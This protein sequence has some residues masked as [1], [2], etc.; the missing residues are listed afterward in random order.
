[1]PA[2]D[3]HRDREPEPRA[4]GLPLG[5]EEGLEDPVHDLRGDAHTVVAHAD[6]HPVPILFDLFSGNPDATRLATGIAAHQRVARVEDQIEEDLLQLLTPRMQDRQLLGQVELD[7]DALLL[8]PPRHEAERPADDLR[9]VHGAH[10]FLAIAS[11]VQQVTHDRGDA[12]GLGDDVV[13]QFLVVVAVLNELRAVEDRVDRVV[14]LVRDAGGE[15]ADRGEAFGLHQHR[16]HLLAI[17][18]VAHD[19]DEFDALPLPHLADRNLTGEGLAI[20][21][22]AHDTPHFAIARGSPS[23]R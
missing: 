20:R 12:L 3:P 10:A 23:R 11:E 6:A 5:G 22:A 2:H 21:A 1:M 7:L 13:D 15:F 4:A 14:D 9:D 8:D 18:D 17:G 19:A 16:R